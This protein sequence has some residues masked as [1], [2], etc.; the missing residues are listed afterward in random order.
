[1]RKQIAFTETNS[2]QTSKLTRLFAALPGEHFTRRCLKHFSSK[3]SQWPLARAILATVAA[4]TLALGLTG[5]GPDTSP[6]KAATGERVYRIAFAFF[7]PDAAAD[8]AINGYLDGLRSEQIEEGRNLEVTRKHAFGEISQ[9]PQMMQSLD[10]QGLDLIVPMTTPGLAAAFGAVK[11]TPMVFVY[12]YDPLGAGAGKSFEDHLP[13]VT[14]VASFPPVEETMKLILQLVPG[15]KKIGTLYNASEANSVKA[16]GVARSVLKDR[17]VTLEEVTIGGT[18]DVLL[19]AQALLARQP[20]A[21]W[22]TGDNTALQALEG[23]IKPTTSAKVPLIL[24]DPEFVDRGALLGVG[25]SWQDSG[26]AAGKLAAR[27]LRGESPA[28]MPIVALA[29]RR[30]VLNHDVAKKLGVVFPPSLIEEAKTP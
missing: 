20:D 2:K 23:I 29:K 1:M 16:V 19:G 8:N 11:Q 12:T 15:A 18:G 14:G 9:L 28:G 25:I 24:N 5:C 26:M 17:G 30:V 3:A 7:G 6:P 27:V 21:V 13:R 4:A 10:T 22:I